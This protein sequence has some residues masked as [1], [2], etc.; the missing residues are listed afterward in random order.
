MS[1]A[2][3]PGWPYVLVH[4]FNKHLRVVKML[5][6]G[7]FAYKLIEGTVSFHLRPN[8]IVYSLYSLQE[9]YLVTGVIFV[10][11]AY[12]LHFECLE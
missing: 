10:S 9:E 4:I 2:H 3:V 6:L 12:E 8:L 1:M 11:R 7:S 5:L